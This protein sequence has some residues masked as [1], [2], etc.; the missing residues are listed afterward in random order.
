MAKEKRLLV[1]YKPVS[2]WDFGPVVIHD[3]N[4]KFQ[5]LVEELFRDAGSG[6]ILVGDVLR[7]LEGLPGEFGNQ[8]A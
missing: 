7:R 4:Q 2:G 8:E 5:S 6:K 3:N 1:K